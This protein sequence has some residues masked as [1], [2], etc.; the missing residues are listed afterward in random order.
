MPLR[1]AQYFSGI[2]MM[3]E[4]GVLQLLRSPAAVEQVLAEAAGG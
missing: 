3:G 1:M 4:N 2:G